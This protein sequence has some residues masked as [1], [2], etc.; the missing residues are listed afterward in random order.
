MERL[1]NKLET[2]SVLI[3][4]DDDFIREK[5]VTILSF[6]FKEV[7]QSD[8]VIDGYELYLENKPDLII[9][10][11]EMKDE[12]GIE[13]IKKIRLIDMGIPIIVISAYS[14]EEYLLNLINLKISHYILKP[15]TN[16]KLYEAITVAIFNENHTMFEIYPSLYLDIENSNLY[17]NKETIPLRKKD[18]HF[19]ELLYKN[20]DK[21]TTYDM[22][23]EYIWVDKDMTQNALKTFIKE[24]RKKLPVQIIENI[25]QEGYRLIKN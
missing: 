3:V 21:I 2:Y 5:L 15:V 14:K 4:E 1:E 18:K 10:D 11:I 23:Q 6:Y 17:Y 13:L 9:T 12:N 7:F 25:I 22:I 16:K 8:N 20:K 19:L 24:L